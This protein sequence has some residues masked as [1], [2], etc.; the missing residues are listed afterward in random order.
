MDNVKEIN[1]KEY[2]TIEDVLEEVMFGFNIASYISDLTQDVTSQRIVL[3]SGEEKKLRK[4]KELCEEVKDILTE[5]DVSETNESETIARQRKALLGFETE[6]NFYKRRIG[7]ILNEQGKKLSWYPDWYKSLEDAVFNE[8]IGFSG[9]TNWL[10]DERY[11]NS[12]A[13]EVVGDRV[14]YEDK[15]EYILQPQKIEKNRRMQLIKSLLLADLKE[16]ESQAWHEIY[17]Q[18]EHLRVTIFKSNGITKRD[19]E[20]ILFRRYIVNNLTFEEH[21][22]RGTIPFEAIP[23]IKNMVKLGP[24]VIFCGPVASGKTT[25]LQTYKREEAKTP[26]Q[27]LSIETDDECQ[28][29][30]I[31][32][33]NYPILQFVPSEK[34]EDTVIVRAKRSDA[35]AIIIGE[36]RHGKYMK[37]AVDSANMGTRRMLTTMH[38]SDILDI[39]YDMADKIVSDCGGNIVTSMVK[40]AKSFNYIWE[41]SSLPN[42]RGSK[43]LLGLWEMYFDSEKME[44]HMHQV[45]KYVPEKDGIEEH[46]VYDNFIS[47]TLAKDFEYE[48]VEV[49]EEFKMQL[50]ELAKQSPNEEKTDFISPYI[51]I[52]LKGDK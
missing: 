5:K 50:A 38:F 6:V 28:W 35:Q 49:F 45:I 39:S 51:R 33:P 42:D 1:E 2:N 26:M 29:D 16:A 10:T 44:I 15:G 8:T 11:K 27:T 7:E 24:N 19:Q 52:F 31:L 25:M 13:C 47:D 41:M 21:A 3:G 9:I 43:R 37:F 18:V 34:E 23:L 14:F 46:W 30:K 4:F 17:T 40:V 22:E 48:N 36:C 12:M 20:V 32:P